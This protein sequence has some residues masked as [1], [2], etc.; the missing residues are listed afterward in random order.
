[1]TLLPIV[2]TR[3]GYYLVKCRLKCLIV[4]GPNHYSSLEE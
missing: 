1:M 2:V 3:L 4:K